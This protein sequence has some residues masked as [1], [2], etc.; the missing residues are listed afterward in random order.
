MYYKYR[1]AY[2]APIFADALANESNI[3][4]TLS[5]EKIVIIR[6]SSIP[7]TWTY[8]FCAT[9]RLAK[10]SLLTAATL[11]DHSQLQVKREVTDRNR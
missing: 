8:S 11:V 3:D 5:Y 9:A 2:R 7:R 4:S 10:D 1:D 6:T